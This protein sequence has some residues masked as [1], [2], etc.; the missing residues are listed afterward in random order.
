MT[1]TDQL[2]RF[3]RAHPGA[4]SLDVTLNLGIVN[5]TG[6]ISDMRQRGYIVD[7]EVREDT[8][9]RRLSRYY[10]REEPVQLSLED[11]A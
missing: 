2:I 1:Q 4:T 6:R 9:G 7:C 10:L 8:A 11:V 3:L 5:V